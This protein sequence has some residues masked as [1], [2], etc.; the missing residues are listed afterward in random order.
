[1]FLKI[2]KL[3]FGIKIKIVKMKSIYLKQKKMSVIKMKDVGIQLSD[4][5]K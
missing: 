4:D 5:H 1:M 2:L 3:L